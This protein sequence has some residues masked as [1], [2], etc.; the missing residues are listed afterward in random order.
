[1][2]AVDEKNI[3]P[4][5]RFLR[6][7][8]GTCVAVLTIRQ[9]AKVSGLFAW[10]RWREHNLPALNRGAQTTKPDFMTWGELMDRKK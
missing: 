8:S 6:S 1:M 4:W 9:A 7:K 2:P 10:N 5:H 3:I